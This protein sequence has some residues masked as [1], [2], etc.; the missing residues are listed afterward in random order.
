[1]RVLI[2]GATGFV[3]SNLT[4]RL[5]AQGEEIAVLMRLQSSSDR[6]ADIIRDLKIFKGDVSDAS[7]VRR[8]M[9]TFRPN[10]VYH[11]AAAGA[12]PGHNDNDRTIMLKSNFLGSW[13][14]VCSAQEVGVKRVI[15]TGTSGVYK[16]SNAPISENDTLAPKTMYAVSKIAAW[17]LSEAVLR[18]TRTSIVNIRLFTP[19]GPWEEQTRLIPYVINK[20]INNEPILLTSGKQARDFIYVDDVVDAL[21][22]AGNSDCDSQIINI[23][24]GKVVT[25][26]DVVN[27]IIKLVGSKS[28]TLF[29]A[30]P[31]RKNEIWE[32][33]ANVERA[34]SVLDWIP[35]T[36]LI[37]GLQKTINWIRRSLSDSSVE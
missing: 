31:H 14:V 17:F 12:S 11:I 28:E 5:H 4:R 30:L 34:M 37:D 22:A 27:I 33:C 10:L 23:G 13:N 26:K 2:T 9:S 36:S 6:V 16:D 7:K 21:I 29:G 25:I 8:A 35:Q 19:F 32:V 20:A 24:S 3:G 15:Y 1:M 18:D